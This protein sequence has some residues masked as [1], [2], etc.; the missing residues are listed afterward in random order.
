MGLGALKKFVGAV[1]N[2]VKYGKQIGKVSQ[3][4]YTC[5]AYG[6]HAKDG[7]KFYTVFDKNGKIVSRKHTITTGQHKAFHTFDAQGNQ[8][9]YSS[10]YK[11]RV[12]SGLAS[13]NQFANKIHNYREKYNKLGQV[14]DSKSI[15]F[16]PSLTGTKATV[17]SNI[18]GVQ[19]KTYL[20]TKTGQKHTITC[21]EK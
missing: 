16:E 2:R 9:V 12:G 13:H 18:N 17:F 3:A 19:S 4:G 10:S 8:T 20:N 21:L 7:S 15:T 1:V 14:I 11:E 6:S 5:R